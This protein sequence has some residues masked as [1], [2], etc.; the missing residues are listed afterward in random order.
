M[1]GTLRV[2]AVVLFFTGL[3]VAPAVRAESGD[4]RHWV[5]TWATSPQA[6]STVFPT[7]FASGFENQT[8]RQAVHISVGGRSVRLR[9][10][11]AF[12]EHAV[13]FDSVYVGIQGA[14]ALVRSG[15]NRRVTFGGQSGV[16]LPV[17]ASAVSDP[18]VLTVEALSNLSISLFTAGATGV[19]TIHLFGSQFGFVSDPG[20]Y[21]A[22]ESD[23]AFLT[24]A[25][26]PFYYLEGVDVLA[27]PSVKGAVLALGDSLTDGLGSTWDANARYPDFL[28]RRLAARRPGQVMSVLNEGMTGN[29][30]LGDSPCFGV[31]VGARLDRDVLARRGVEVVIYSQGTNDFGFPVVDA[32]A[33]GLPPEC[34][35]P[36]T[37]V[38]VEEVI[39]G[40]RQVIARVHA[41]GIRIL[42]GTLNPI[43]NGF[44][45]SPETEVKRQALN[46]WIEGSGEF[47]GV[48][49]F[50]SAVADPSDPEALAP[51]YDSGDHLHPND[52][53]YQAM[54]NAVNLALLK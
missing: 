6:A 53:G 5:G 36:A 31:N 1:K 11:N 51:W 14:G 13:R 23:A 49:D 20:D 37:E 43:K 45:W 12:G 25:I 46:A 29:R 9:L 28:A 48:V 40:Y 41:A 32:D 8:I 33:I 35:Q 21:S 3:V 2:I 44:E 30:V 22:S 54:A 24:P 19:P 39:A 4:G 26:G 50:A 52:A 7:D 42:G 34:F 17:G 18:V 47:D 16:T 15:T 27:D 38:S 10:T